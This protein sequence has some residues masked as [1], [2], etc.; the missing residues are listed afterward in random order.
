VKA[1][2]KQAL[3][4]RIAPDPKE[5]SI[6]DSVYLFKTGVAFEEYLGWYWK[7]FV[8][9]DGELHDEWLI[10][11]ERLKAIPGPQVVVH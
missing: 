10:H 2:E 3:V 1:E 9:E 8:T 4:D 7:V 6:W 5:D 11:Q